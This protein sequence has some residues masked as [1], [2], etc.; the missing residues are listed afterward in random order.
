MDNAEI[1]AT[2]DYVKSRMDIHDCVARYTRGMD[3]LDRASALSAFHE[4]AVLEYGVFVGSPAEFFDYFEKLHRSH[5]KSTNHNICNHVCEIDGD[6]AHTETY[7][8]VANNNVSGAPCSLAG[9]RYVDRFERRN[10][11]WAIATRVCVGEWDATPGGNALAETLIAKFREIISISRDRD[12]VSYQRPLTVPA[13]R[14]GTT[15]SV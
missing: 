7:F 11:R 6:T 13:E 9:G 3:R 5:H 8:A 1:E 10:G 15:L 14:I 2:L 4:D 12:D